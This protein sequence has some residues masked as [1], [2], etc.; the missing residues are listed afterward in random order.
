MMN[1]PKEITMIVREFYNQVL[2][3]RLTDAQWEIILKN[4][5]WLFDIKGDAQIKIAVLNLLGDT[6]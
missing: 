6:K 5:K 4:T 3:K 2:E 1:N